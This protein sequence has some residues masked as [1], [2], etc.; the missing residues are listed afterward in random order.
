MELN[1]DGSPRGNTVSIG[2]QALYYIEAHHQ[3]IFLGG[4]LKLGVSYQSEELNT[5]QEDIDQTS[6]FTSWEYR[7]K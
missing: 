1:E 6:V 2:A 5:P 3:R 7:F 4:K